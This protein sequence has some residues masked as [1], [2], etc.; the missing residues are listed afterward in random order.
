MTVWSQ[1]LP[2]FSVHGILRARILE[3]VPGDLP[4]PGIKPH[5][6]R[7]LRWQAGNVKAGGTLPLVPPGKPKWS[8]LTGF[9]TSRILIL[10]VVSH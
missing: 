10:L 8:C 4:D 1:R 2:V 5:L 7:L 3:S 9:T 6:L